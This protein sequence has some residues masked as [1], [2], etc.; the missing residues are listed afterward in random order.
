MQKVASITEV[1][2]SAR[3]DMV[4]GSHQS[5]LRARST[6]LA[7][8][9]ALLLGAVGER[10]ALK[11]QFIRIIAFRRVLDYKGGLLLV[12]HSDTS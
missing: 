4:A 12:L 5:L 7:T 6:A 1:G 10:G 9:S 3:V 11:G 8:Q 2:G